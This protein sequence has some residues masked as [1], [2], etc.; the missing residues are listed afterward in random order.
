MFLVKMVY[1]SSKVGRSEVIGDLQ[2]AA[3]AA[4]AREGDTDEETGLTI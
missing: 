3:D 2:H 4:E 1:S